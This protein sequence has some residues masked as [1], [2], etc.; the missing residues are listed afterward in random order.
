MVALCSREVTSR[1][2]GQALKLVK[3]GGVLAFMGGADSQDLH[4]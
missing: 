4:I 1:G 2:F 3:S